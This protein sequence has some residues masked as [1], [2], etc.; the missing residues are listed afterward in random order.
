ML[1]QPVLLPRRIMLLGCPWRSRTK[2]L[3]LESSSGMGSQGVD[4]SENY[5]LL[6]PRG[7]TPC[8]RRV[9][10][11]AQRNCH[12]NGFSSKR[13]GAYVLALTS[14]P[15]AAGLRHVKV[16][17]RYHAL[18]EY[19]EAPLAKLLVGLVLFENV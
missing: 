9:A 3:F 18:R 1:A 16:K 7:Q 4:T 15:Y 5:R 6:P 14:K 12:P 17:V 10:L 13:A 2:A 19:K 8:V 11:G